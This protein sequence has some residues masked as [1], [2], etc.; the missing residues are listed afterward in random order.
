MKQGEMLA[1]LRLRLPDAA[2]ETDALLS[3]LLEDAG[4]LIRALTWR[5]ETPAGLENAQVRLGAVLYNRMGMEGETEHQEGDVRRTAAVCPRSCAGKFWP[6][7]W[8]KPEGRKR[9]CG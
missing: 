1:A 5:E 4:A 7:G 2:A 8:P 3:G 9:G 6:T